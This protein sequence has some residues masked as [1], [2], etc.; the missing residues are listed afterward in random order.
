MMGRNDLNHSTCSSHCFRL[1]KL[2]KVERQAIAQTVDRA[3]RTRDLL[4]RAMASHARRSPGPAPAAVEAASGVYTELQCGSYIVMDAD[5]GKNRD[6]RRRAL[7][8][9]RAE[10]LRLEDGD[11]PPGLSV[12][13]GMGGDRLIN[14]RVFL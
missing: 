10:P 2:V 13:R 12:K 5:Y 3:G 9:H 7:R 1:E 6:P 4:A 14:T 11:E 8:D